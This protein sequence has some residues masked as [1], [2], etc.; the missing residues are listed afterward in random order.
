MAKGGG[1]MTPATILMMNDDV[2]Q[3]TQL[4]V[5]SLFVE[6]GGLVPATA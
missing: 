6:I 2:M 4:F 3:A 5:F 1:D